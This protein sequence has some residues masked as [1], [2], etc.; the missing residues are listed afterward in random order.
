MKKGLPLVAGLFL[1]SA[2]AGCLNVQAPERVYV[3]GGPQPEK[4][5]S[6]RVPETRTHE[7]AR[8]ELTKAY[9]QIQ[10]LE[11][12]NQRLTRKLDDAKAKKE[13]AER[14]YEKLKDKHKD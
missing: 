2:H 5:D 14:K 4:V 7:E 3:G 11:H 9:R 1:L 12:E 13:E 8:A 10:Y 6:S